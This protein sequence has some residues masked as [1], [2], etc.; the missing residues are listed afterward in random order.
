[1]ISARLRLVMSI[2]VE[3]C[4]SERPFS[5]FSAR[6][7]HPLRKHFVA[8]QIV[9]FYLPGRFLQVEIYLYSKRLKI[10][11]SNS[12][13]LE[14]ELCCFVKVFWNIKNSRKKCRVI[15][16]TIVSCCVNVFNTHLLVFIQLQNHKNATRMPPSVIP[17]CAF[18]QGCSLNCYFSF[19]NWSQISNKCTCQK[20]QVLWKPL[21]DDEGK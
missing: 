12:E 16:I 18:F 11:N 1:M 6:I 7:K 14:W 19:W 9:S 5:S 3:I 8:L 20:V 21:Y 4:S 13:L 17:I 2:A 15:E 10:S